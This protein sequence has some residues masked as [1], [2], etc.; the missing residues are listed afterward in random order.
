M[1]PDQVNYCLRCGTRLEKG[2]RFGKLR[3]FCPQCDWIYF[4]DPRVAVAVLIEQEGK[5]LLVRRSVDPARGLWTLPAGFLDAGEDPEWA[6]QREC[7]EETGLVVHI[8]ELLE[9]M[10]EQAHPKGAHIILFYRAKVVSGELKAEDDVDAAQFFSP[11]EL[12]PLAFASTQRLLQHL[13]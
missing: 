2:E 3:P 12:P 9:V 4:P 6:A 13:N 10:A 8:T 11:Q 1:E 5:V 7:L